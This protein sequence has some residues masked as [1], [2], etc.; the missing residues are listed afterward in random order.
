MLSNGEAVIPAA[1]VRE[2]PEAINQ[3]I[4]GKIPGYS[5]GGTA[6]RVTFTQSGTSEQVSNLRQGLG[7][8]ADLLEV[9]L[10]RLTVT[11]KDGTEE[12]R[13]GFAEIRQ[14]ATDEANKQGRQNVA[15]LTGTKSVQAHAQHN[16]DPS[17][18]AYKNMMKESGY[19]SPIVPQEIKNR[20]KGVGAFTG[21]LP[22][23][24][25]QR[26]VARKDASGNIIGGG[27]TPERFSSAWNARDDKFRTTFEKGGIDYGD[28]K[29]A[30][31]ARKYEQELGKRSLELAQAR[32]E[33]TGAVGKVKVYDDDLANAAVELAA[34]YREP[35]RSPAEQKVGAAA[36]Q[37]MDIWGAGRPELGKDMVQQYV[38]EAEAGRPGFVPKVS[39]KDGRVTNEAVFVDPTTGESVSNLARLGQSR[40]WSGTAIANKEGYFGQDDQSVPSAAALK[41]RV[42]AQAELTGDPTLGSQG[43]QDGDGYIE[44]L[45]SAISEKAPN[46]IPS[47]LESG[48]WNSP[49]PKWVSQGSEDGQGYQEAF[50]AAASGTGKPP[51]PG[52]L[53]APKPPVQA[54]PTGKSGIGKKLATRFEDSSIGK[55]IGKRLAKASGNAVTD[56]SGQVYYDPN[57]DMSTWAGQMTAKDKKSRANLPGGENYS[58][59][60]GSTVSSGVTPVRV[61]N[62]VEFSPELGDALESGSIQSENLA[63]T[64]A[65]SQEITKKKQR[66]DADIIKESKRQNRQRGAG[67][68]LGVLGTATMVAGMA[69]QV[70]GRVGE[71]AQQVVGPLAAL[72]GILP[73]L[74]S[75]GPV[76]GSLVA[77]IGLV[78]AGFFV[79]N[80]TLKDTAKETYELQR[81]MG[82]S[83][84]AI[85]SFAEFS[86][87][88]TQTEL[89]QEQ[90]KERFNPFVVAAG[91]STF[92]ENFAQEDVGQALIGNIRKSLADLGRDQTITS[93]FLQL[94]QA[95]GEGALSIPEARSIAT[96]LGNQLG[97]MSFGMEV[98]ANLMR[99]LGPGGEDLLAGDRLTI[100]ADLR[101]ERQRTRADMEYSPITG[102]EDRTVSSDRNLRRSE[103]VESLGGGFGGTV[104]AFFSSGEWHKLSFELATGIG[105]AKDN[106]E[107]L[108]TILAQG[109]NDADFYASQM[110]AVEAVYGD[111]LEKAYASNDLYEIN[112]L[113]SERSEELQKILADRQ[114]SQTATLEELQKD[115]PKTRIAMKE[116]LAVDFG[117]DQNALAQ[118]TNALKQIQEIG[119][120]EDK[121]L[122]L[123]YMLTSGDMPFKTAM[124]IVENYERMPEISNKIVEIQ[125]KF[126]GDFSGDAS[127]LF[128]V[129]KEIDEV[130]ADRFILSLDTTDIDK[131]QKQIEGFGAVASVQALFPEGEDIILKYVLENPEEID[132]INDDINNLKG[133]E[134]KDVTID[135][136]A[137]HFGD[138]ALSA[139]KAIWDEIP[140]EDRKDALYSIIASMG[141]VETP[142]FQELFNALQGQTIAGVTISKPADILSMLGS[143]VSGVASGNRGIGGGDQQQESSG[144]SPKEFD[145]L[146][147][148]LRDLRLA[149]IDMRRGWDGMMRSLQKVFEGGTKSINVFEGLSNQIRRLGVGENLIEMIVG[150][151]P[152]EYNK[153]K[154][155][156]FVFDKGGNIVGVTAKLNNMQAAFNAIAL[157]EYVNEQ[158]RNIQSMRDQISAIS[159]LT[160]NGLS[161]AE[162]YELVQ[163]EALAAA[164]ALGA[165][166]EE[167]AE[168]IR[169]TKE[170]E[171]LRKKTEAEQ[172]RAATS[173]AVRKTNEDFE[174]RVAILNKL[175]KAAGQYSNAQIEAILGDSNLGKLFLDPKIDSRALE[176]ALANAARGAQLEIDI[177]LASPSGRNTLFEEG[178]GKAMEALAIQEQTID[179]DFR[180]GIADDESIIRSAESQI[181]A[182]QFELDDYQAEITRI[183]DQEK[184]IN[185]AY[186]KRFEALDKIAKSN[187]AIAAAQKS[188]LDIAD[189]LTRGDIAGA[190]RAA[191][192]A[193]SEQAGRAAQEERSQL[194][195]ARDAQI[196]AL[197]GRG[198]LNR[199]QLEQQIRELEMQV[200][201]LEEDLLEPAQ[202]RIRL[203]QE[204]RDEQVRSLE[205]LGKT[206]EEWEAIR[207][208]V[209]VAR[210]NNWE[211]V[212]SMQRALDLVKQIIEDLGKAKPP[213]PPP[214]PPPAPRAASAPA[215][216]P[217]S[218]PKTTAAPA[219][220]PR[221][222]PAPAPNASGSVVSGTAQE[223][224]AVGLYGTPVK[225][226]PP[227]PPTRIISS[228]THSSPPVKM[229][230]GIV[231]SYIT[232]TS[233]LSNAQL[234]AEIARDDRLARRNFSSGGMIIP[235]RMNI[236]GM[237]KGYAAGGFSMG[238]DIIPAM[239]TPG[240]FVV[241]KRAVQ[242]FG[243]ENLEKINSGTYNDGSVYNYNLAVNVKSDSDPDKIARTV[244]KHIDRVESQKIR[245]NKL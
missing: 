199:E 63:D 239:L 104:A 203:A 55:G 64:M 37:R 17:S 193:R 143:R 147:K 230:T 182:L 51:L 205:V 44:S 135:F 9:V 213:P 30:A 144:G 124:A 172:E 238:S 156:L 1:V 106:M 82:T 197:T 195:R 86:G 43:G 29:E 94:G 61:V 41:A 38:A 100:L 165:T 72:S 22:S 218:A 113:E 151:D 229:G 241:R 220:A 118:Y 145:P 121:T 173:K 120:E 34:E 184:D 16:L 211:F 49:H 146:I 6:G 5:E 200:F 202:E 139:A 224:A 190:A 23:D 204:L 77:I 150:M 109:V 178:F 53:E 89:Y 98:N 15:G 243:M 162:A 91:K 234:A 24:V 50:D 71:V 231:T 27:E 62:Q 101:E 131:Y 129:F 75:L 210:M 74:M 67:R 54:T 10:K 185:D 233:S 209:D 133:I 114:A 105:A 119:L 32:H 222:A 36:Q 122:Q 206:R 154:K 66:Q 244:M 103:I 177:K 189:A 26:L 159:I 11:L 31:A 138:P 76:L 212:E 19:D 176:Q 198:G 167:I 4:S 236:G 235:K 110:A 194:E 85:Q 93:I 192:E 7:E 148:K 111:S 65:K 117:D 187:E 240:E 169:L 208:S 223:R 164:I 42:Q 97:D 183:E 157:G 21:G 18:D 242:N 60:L 174:Q 47:L 219:S 68:A 125:T 59:D 214:P 137:Q 3:L 215:P 87:K 132:R 96:A 58:P 107:Q 237:V 25:N 180:A 40:A 163:N 13:A 56:S 217:A 28:D 142:E 155:D 245:G 112:R 232:N 33:A 95:I 140:V 102:N 226:T 170:V 88:V 130:L 57:E 141:V 2:N 149:T 207:N 39:Q 171:G 188:Q 166:R 45:S 14:A 69:T 12:V 221:P 216:A 84:K 175:S 228:P 186:E 108:S 48:G 158:Q 52:N 227:P 128:N 127:E 81:A 83:K 115:I 225:T 152:D 90:R 181:A 134:N 136:I 196:A 35:S 160:A 20:V 179:I 161:L 92:G 123:E 153:R 126:G 73:I 8:N 79:Y 78:A 201:N 168:I 191:R 70:E 99:L 80:K 46:V 116:A